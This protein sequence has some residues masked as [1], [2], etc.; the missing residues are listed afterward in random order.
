[1]SAWR[2]IALGALLSFGTACAALNYPTEGSE[3]AAPATPTPSEEAAGPEAPVLLGLGFGESERSL[4]ELGEGG[5]QEWYEL[6]RQAREDRQL[7]EFDRARERLDQA[8]LQLAGRPAGNAQRRAV[9]GMRARLALDFAALQRT[10][11]SAALA[12]ALF[13]E[14]EA[15]PA[16]GG[17]AT[18]DLALHFANVRA[19]AAEEAGL[20]ESQLPLLRI[21]LL[22]SEDGSPSTPRLSLA[23]RVFQEAMTEGD[24]QL[25]RRAIDRSLLDARTIHPGNLQ[26]L[27]SI[28]VFRARV[29]R[30]EGDLATAEAS[31]IAAN[32]LFDEAGADSDSRAVGEA[33]LAVIVAERGDEDRARA[34]LAAADA[35]LQSEAGLN[36]HS[37]R[38]VLG[39]SARME[40]ALGNPEAARAF[41][42]RALDLP[43]IDFAA[44]VQLV[45]ELTRELAALDS[46]EGENEGAEVEDD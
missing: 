24:L 39:E 23:Y 35:R 12:D 37:A 32:R 42:V 21:A 31:A 30:A 5:E 14:V 16:I 9:H 43:A 46:P 33:T 17:P 41:F 27:A 20:H 19:A 25:A 7:G 34:I 29:A 45:E 3:P 13:E 6:T 18:I 36:D 2:L 38:T 10:D 26:Q 8:A 44:D 22:A 40:R 1:M 11:D 28:N 15:G 4:A